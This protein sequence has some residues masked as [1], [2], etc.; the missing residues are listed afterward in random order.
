MGFLLS[1]DE[2]PREAKKYLDTLCHTKNSTHINQSAAGRR[3]T[4]TNS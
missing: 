1:R 3:K 4:N 2:Y